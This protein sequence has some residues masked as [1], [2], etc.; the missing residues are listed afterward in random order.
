VEIN[1]PN[2][3]SELLPGAYARVDIKAPATAGEPSF[4]V[5]SN[6]LLFRPEGP[7]VAL[8]GSDGKV[9]LQPVTIKRELGV[10]V[11]LGSGVKANDRIVL[12]PADSLA[13]GDVVVVAPPADKKPETKKAG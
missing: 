1:L 11:E 8:V 4:R 5:P 3:K 7:R 13:D 10:E 2:P 9:H 6:T 12:N